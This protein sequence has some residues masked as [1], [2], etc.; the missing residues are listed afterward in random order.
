M[1]P[2]S[3]GFQE[4][5]R[6]IR[7]LLANGHNAEALITLVFT[8]EKTLRRAL[9]FCAV[10]RGFTS[11]QANALFSNMGFKDLKDVWP[12]FEKENRSLP[13]FVGNAKWQHVPPAITM[14]NKL[15]HGEEFTS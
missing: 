4:A 3:L 2:V 8:F 12:C 7:A 6:R 15:V 14:R 11:K 9:R 13:D 10:S 5:E 1:Y